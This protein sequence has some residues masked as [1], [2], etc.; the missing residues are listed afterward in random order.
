MNLPRISIVTP[1]FN[2][3]Q[4]LPDCLHSVLAQDYP[5]LEYLVIDGGSTD[6]S[7]EILKKLEDRLAYWVSEPDQGQAQAV[8]KG[9]ARA[10][11]EV[12][13]WVNS[14]DLLTPGALARV[15]ASYLAHPRAALIF[16]DV[17][18]IN[19]AG[20]LVRTKRMAGFDLRSLIL[21]K[22]M[23]QPGV[24]VSRRAYS[25]LGGL[26]ESLHYALDFDFFL[27]A[28]LASS[29]GDFVYL[30]AVLAA[31][32]LWTQSKTGQNAARF[33]AEYRRVLDVTF[34]RA[35]LPQEIKSLKQRAYSR[36][37]LFRQAR[38][39]FQARKN[40]LGLAWLTRSVAR[41]PSWIEKAHMMWFGL[42]CL[43]GLE[44]GEA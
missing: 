16:G 37:F 28:W 10:S 3:V 38:L 12:L 15:S 29:A 44:R 1:S 35:D 39:Y 23:G 20:R 4:Y 27:R 33:G 43:L 5:N 19:A 8:N 11:G 24:F 21:G 36:A 6:G 2:Q 13:G 25:K 26:D 31:S 7:L 41:E 14:D 17:Q 30:P 42:R 18:E 34:Q 22:N 32:R 9:W 40:I